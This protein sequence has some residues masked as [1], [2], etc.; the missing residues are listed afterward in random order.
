FTDNE[1]TLARVQFSSV[2][3]DLVFP[4]IG[5]PYLQET[6]L[7]IRD[8]GSDQFDAGVEYR[9]DT[10]TTPEVG[11]NSGAVEIQVAGT[12]EAP[13]V[14]RGRQEDAGF[15]G[16][17]II[18][19]NVL[20]NSSLNYLEIHHAGGDE[21]YA[22]EINAEIELNHVSLLDNELGVSI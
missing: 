2:N 20:S 6:N 14:F 22:L 12:E 9:F 5:M 10:D 21:Q 11:W 16:G 4:N 19:N 3:T 15:W 1:E 17:L 7:Q 8:G 18:E 13:V